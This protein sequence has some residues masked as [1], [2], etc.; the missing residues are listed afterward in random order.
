MV[1]LPKPTSPL[2]WHSY[3]YSGANWVGRVGPFMTPGSCNK[4]VFRTFCTV[5]SPFLL[6][7]PTH[8][9][10]FQIFPLYL[11]LGS[12][13]WPLHCRVWK[14]GDG[15]NRQSGRNT[16]IPIVSAQSQ[17]SSCQGTTLDYRLGPGRASPSSFSV[18]KQG[19]T[20]SKVSRRLY[21]EYTY[22][23]QMWVSP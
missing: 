9:G 8:W 15:Q 21:A 6:L 16:G 23:C 2:T 12:S 19:E 18:S 22:Y 4:F 10:R 7:G 20:Q 11:W 1:T 3:Q 13:L 17:Q 5:H 14:Q